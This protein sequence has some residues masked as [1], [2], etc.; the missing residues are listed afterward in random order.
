MRAFNVERLPEG[1]YRAPT[2]EERAVFATVVTERKAKE[3]ADKGAVPSLINPT[4]ADAEKLQ[5]RWNATAKARDARTPESAVLRMTQAEYS[6]RSKGDGPCE[7][8]DISEQLRIRRTDYTGRDGGGRVT[9]FKVRTGIAGGYSYS[10]ARRVIV[11]TD[12]PQKALPW[13]TAEAI[14]ETMPTVEM[15]RSRLA[16]LAELIRSHRLSMEYTAEEKQLL[17]DAAYVGWA[18]EASASQR[19]WTEVGAAVYKMFAAQVEAVVV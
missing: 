1:A 3:K 13:S 2:D 16:E 18:Y 7:T 8:S 15:L 19:G 17:A 10:A 11:L 12:K 4:D 5:A 6:A 9:V 14:R